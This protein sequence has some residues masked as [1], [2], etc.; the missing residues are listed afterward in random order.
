MPFNFIISARDAGKTTALWNDKVYK[1]FLDGKPSL[2]LRRNQVDITDVYISDIGEVINKFKDEPI[3]LS[4]KKGSLKDGVAD[5]FVDGKLFIRVIA[6]S[7]PVS[8][9]KSLILRNIAYLVFDEFIC[10]PRLG[11][12]YL[13][14]ESFR[15]KE[16]FNTFQRET[17]CLKCYFL[18]NPYSLYNPYF[19]WLGVNTKELH[20]GALLKGNNWVIEC[21]QI[22]DELKSMLLEKNPLYSFDDSYKEYAFDGLAINDQKIPL[23]NRISGATLS[24]VLKSGE[25]N[26]AI[27]KNLDFSYHIELINIQDISKRRTIWI[28]DFED[29]AN[30]C[31]LMNREDTLRFRN[32]V[33]AIRINKVDY[34]TI[35]C[36]Y[37]IKEIYCKL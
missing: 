31:V 1:A 32:F 21:Y 16:L 4:F 35:E 17:D 30:N 11:E 14:N 2:V 9:I 27:Y 34:S 7:N 20:Q 37:L 15:F 24:L 19:T 5:I 6:L 26:L 18:G 22:S 36:Y 10:N 3:H 25:K 13:K 33:N 12:K 8:R 29:I 28:V 23:G